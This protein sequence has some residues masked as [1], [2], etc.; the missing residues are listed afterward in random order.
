MD[1]YCG[2]NSHGSVCLGTFKLLN[3]DHV[4]ASALLDNDLD[5]ITW[6]PALGVS[7]IF[8]SLFKISGKQPAYS[9]NEETAWAVAH[10]VA[11]YG[12]YAVS[13][14]KTHGALKAANAISDSLFAE[15]SGGLV[16]L[17]VDD[18]AGTRSDSIIYG[19]KF[20]SGIEMP[21]IKSGAKTVYEDISKALDLSHERKIPHAVIIDTVDVLGGSLEIKRKTVSRKIT[22]FVRR[23]ECKVVCPMLT[24]YQ[25]S[26]LDARLSHKDPEAVEFDRLPSIPEDIPPYWHP[27]IERYTPLMNALKL[28]KSDETIMVS[29]IGFFV[30][31]AFP[32]FSVQDICTFMGGSISTAAGT[33]KAGCRDAWAV[34][35]D[36]SFIGAGHLALI[37]PGILDL[38]VKVVILDNGMSETTGG[39]KIPKDQLKTV[40]SLA[41]DRVT[42]AE[43]SMD[44]R[45]CKEV[46][47]DI[48]KQPG[49]RIAVFNYKV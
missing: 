26:I 31:F 21:F 2:D 15:L 18:I 11:M 29:D 27:A 1:L 28:I 37:E 7:E 8:D 16:L 38:P 4:I 32:P 12:G 45:V 41:G 17:V 19:D 34:T 23:P 33:V 35:G 44:Q 48:K 30:S 47:L 6:L 3:S 13:V 40:L 36:F 10:G 49:L 46:L 39:Q 14:M 22:S 24:N 9:F 20:L 25:R 5:L 43:N 42:Y